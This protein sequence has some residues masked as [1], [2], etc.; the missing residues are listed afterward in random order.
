MCV[1]S[2]SCASQPK[3]GFWRA[4]NRQTERCNST[5]RAVVQANAI[6]Q[7]DGEMAA[8][9]ARSRVFC[10][11]AQRRGTLQRNALAGGELPAELLC[12]H[13]HKRRD[14]AR[15]KRALVE[16]GKRLQAPFRFIF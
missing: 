8:Q 6:L 7:R 3:F 10:Q 14:P 15:R 9:T 13:A 1:S 16:M 5:S 2:R 4:L 11:R 12:P